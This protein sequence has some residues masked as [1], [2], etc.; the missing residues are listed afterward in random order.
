MK[1]SF[2]FLRNDP[3]HT[4]R[5]QIDR[6]FSSNDKGMYVYCINSI[7]VKCSETISTSLCFYF[8]SISSLYYDVSSSIES[9]LICWILIYSILMYANN[10]N[11]ILLS[12]V[13]FYSILF[14]TLLLL[15]SIHL[16]SHLQPVL[17]FYFYSVLFSVIP[18]SSFSFILFSSLLFYTFLSSSLFCRH[19]PCMQCC[20]WEV[21]WFLLSFDSFFIQ[22]ILV[23]ENRQ[24]LI[25]HQSTGC[26]STG[27]GRMYLM[28]SR[29]SLL[30]DHLLSWKCTAF[31]A[32]SS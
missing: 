4:D 16:L 28:H 14:S 19:S 3:H 18:Y 27:G 6:S 10:A 32:T 23:I 1:I 24:R 13:L 31:W 22:A 20:N 8:M 21:T 15:L 5:R 26:Q 2:Y 7:S 30:L 9:T 25:C 17:F 29:T 11:S 12:S